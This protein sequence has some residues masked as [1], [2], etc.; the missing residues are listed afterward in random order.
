MGKRGVVS[1]EVRGGTKLQWLLQIL[2]G[3]SEDYDLYPNKLGAGE[4][5]NLMGFNG[6]LLAAVSRTDSPLQSLWDIAGGCNIHEMMP[7]GPWQ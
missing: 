4:G 5:H 7:A 3:P 1:L 2:L 6:M